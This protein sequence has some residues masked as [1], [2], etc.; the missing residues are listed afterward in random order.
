MR[1]AYPPSTQ[2]TRFT[3]LPTTAKYASPAT[4]GIP[5]SIAIVGTS[6]SG[7]AGRVNSRFMIT[8]PSTTQE[9]MPIPNDEAASA[10]K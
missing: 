6:T 2:A 1:T 4:A 10:C 3:V 7:S 5:S 8:E 9:M